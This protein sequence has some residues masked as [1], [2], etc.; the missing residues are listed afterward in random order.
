MPKS[1]EERLDQEYAPAWRPEPGGILIGTVTDVDE[2]PGTDWGPYP[3]VTIETADGE[4][5][6]VHAFHTVLRN[7]ILKLAPVEG[8]GLGI[9]Y[10]GKSKTKSG[11]DVELYAVKIDR[12][13]P[14]VR[15]A[16][17]APAASAPSAP[18]ATAEPS[19]PDWSSEEPF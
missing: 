11:A 12:K 19:T 2:A 15:A 14:R 5:F 3:V 16:A 4:E 10:K 17:G 13:T 18:A 6:A 1:M 7:E 8:D 9:K